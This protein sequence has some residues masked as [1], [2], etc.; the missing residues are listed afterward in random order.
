MGMDVYGRNPTG[1][2]GEYFRSSAP[3][4]YELANYCVHVA[5]DICASCKEW[6]TNDCDGLDADGAA[7]LATVLQ[8]EVNENRTVAYATSLALI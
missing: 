2:N 1:E 4:W 5:P 7:R 3:A 6:R 8:N